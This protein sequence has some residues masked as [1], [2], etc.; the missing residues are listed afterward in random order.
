LGALLALAATLAM[1]CMPSAQAGHFSG[2]NSGTGCFAVNMADNNTHS[3]FYTAAVPQYMR[4]A[5]NAARAESY[6]PTDINTVTSTDANSGTDV[7][8]YQ[9]DYSTWCGGTWHP[10]GGTVAHTQCVSIVASNGRCQKHE[11]R[12]DESF[13]SITSSALRKHVACHESGHTLGLN[14]R[15]S[16]SASCMWTGS[17]YTYIDQHDRDALN[18]NY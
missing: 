4:D 18:A 15:T 7:V 17:T 1:L 12:F 13:V 3:F 9:Q 6:D 5:I 14:H 11:M 2:A 10:A 8:T 16:S